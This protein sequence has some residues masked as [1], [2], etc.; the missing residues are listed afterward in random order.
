TPVEQRYQP[1]AEDRRKIATIATI[2]ANSIF[3]LT[4]TLRLPGVSSPEP[5]VR[6]GR[7][8]FP[9]RAGRSF[10]KRSPVRP[11]PSPPSASR[12][13]RP[14]S[15]SNLHELRRL[16]LAKRVGSRAYSLPAACCR[17]AAGSAGRIIRG[18][19]L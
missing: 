7:S 12:P 6:G 19:I 18:E 5:R 11:S 8:P 9:D 10:S 17:R 15:R 16:L 14:R 1:S 3:G 2:S 4:H 13:R